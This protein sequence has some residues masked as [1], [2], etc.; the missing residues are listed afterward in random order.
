MIRKEINNSLEHTEDSFQKLSIQVSLNGLSFCVLDTI[1]KKLEVSYS[2][3]FHK[4]LT[5][6]ELENE[7]RDAL[8]EKDIPNYRFSEVVVIHKN[9]LYSLVPQALFQE[10]EL[11]NYLKFNAKIFAT[12]HLDYDVLEGLEAVNVYVPFANVNNHIYELFGEF[13]FKHSG[14]VLLETL[15]KL[16]LSG[17]GKSCYVHLS[18]SQMDMAIFSNKQLLFYNSFWYTTEE[19]FMYYLLFALEQLQLDPGTLKLR[20][21]GDV[22]EGDPLVNL[23]GEYLEQVSLFIPASQNFEERENDPPL[24]FT[25]SSTL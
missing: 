12:D 4:E 15:I 19:D 21:M 13:E 11:S 2:R 3:T 9:A 5:P 20:L 6:F 17:Q 22:E 18:E 1:G 25:L 24:D 8:R 23:C 10:E 16:P 7:L 14:T